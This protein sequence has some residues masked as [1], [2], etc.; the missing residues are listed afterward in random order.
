MFSLEIPLLITI[1][2]FLKSSLNVGYCSIKD[3]NIFS[4]LSLLSPFDIFKNIDRAIALILEFMLLSSIVFSNS[5]KISIAKVEAYFP[6]NLSIVLSTA[7][8]TTFFDVVI[9]SHK[10]AI[11]ML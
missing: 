6:M 8:L 11:A 5:T 9:K 7:N 4:S 1:T 2:S 10:A 3:L